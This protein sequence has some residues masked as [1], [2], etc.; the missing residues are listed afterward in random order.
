VPVRCPWRTR[1]E[2]ALM[3][4]PRAANRRISWQQVPGHVRHAVEAALGAA[5]VEA[6]TQQRG[7]SPGAAARLRLANGGTAFVK[8]LGVDLHRYSVGLYRHEAATMP[9]LPADLPV[10]RL[11]DVYDDGE[12]VALVYEEVDGRHPAVPWRPDELDRVAGAVADLGAALQPSPWPDAPGFA[13]GNGTFLGA[14][15]ELAAAP[16]PDLDPWLRRNLDGLAAS[17]IDLV[18]VVGGDALLHTDIRSDNL[19]LT[20]DGG[21][22]V[23]DWGWTC[24]G[25]PWLAWCCS[26]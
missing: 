3:A 11:L 25:A 21:V 9:H 17:G 15:R 12:W 7:F 22:V 20:P 18:E 10:P 14:W 8:A 1:G 2:T 4:S 16:P 24:H 5:V 13:E 23:L 19:L 6:H 26:P